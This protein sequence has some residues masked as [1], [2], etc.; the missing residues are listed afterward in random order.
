MIDSDVTNEQVISKM[1][2]QKLVLY[3]ITFVIFLQFVYIVKMHYDG[4]APVFTLVL[5]IS[6]FLQIFVMF[7]CR[8]KFKFKNFVLIWSFLAFFSVACLIAL[9]G[10]LKAP[11]YFWLFFF[12]ILLGV[13]VGGKHALLSII[14]VTITFI[15]FY[16]F[17][18]H[19]SVPE[20]LSEEKAFLNA[21]L[22]SAGFFTFAISVF[23]YLN[24]NDL[25]K[26]KL[27]LEQKKDQ[28]D[29]LIRVMCHDLKND[30]FVIEYHTDRL[31]ELDDVNQRRLT[32]VKKATDSIKAVTLKVI[33]W[34]SH[35]AENYNELK[36]VNI[37]EILNSSLETFEE[38]LKEKSLNL[39]LSLVAKELK[40]LVDP[41][42]L[43]IQIFNN[44]LS[45]AIKFTPDGGHIN[46]YTKKVGRSVEI[47]VLDSG[48]GISD[49][50]KKDILKIRKHG[51]TEGTRG[52]KG[53][54]FGIPL[55]YQFVKEFG[56]DIDINS[57]A[58]IPENK[59]PSL[60]GTAVVI[61]LPLA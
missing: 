13:F 45:N 14:P 58:N 43:E 17:N 49:V 22:V 50:Q 26:S 24:H 34:S 41:V 56:G 29:R 4:F 15:L 44:L 32:K 33:N 3:G 8:S 1:E 12:P 27:E 2:R 16:V 55:L 31:I 42:T 52:E 6:T 28:V 57:P 23:M 51:S 47:G 7:C 59:D 48:V 25:K 61:R 9:S 60:P 39:K 37:N 21:K 40:A 20:N 5:G 38:R 36:P 18:D 19:L 54:G 30:L 53:T 11:G 35:N 46:V 10:G